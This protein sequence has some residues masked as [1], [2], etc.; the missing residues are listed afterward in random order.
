MKRDRLDA[1]KELA[2]LRIEDILETLGV[3]FTER[4]NYVV[5][6][7]PVHGGSRRDAFS[8]HLERGIWKCF[9]RGCEEEHGADIFGLVRAIRKCTFND[10]IRFIE[11]FVDSSLS[12]EEIQRLK[13]KKA[14]KEFIQATQKKVERLKTYDPSCLSKLTKHG[15]LETRGYPT[16]L[17]ERYHIGAC[18]E[19]HRYMSNRIVVPVTN[20]D[21]EI[22]GFTG[23]TL[24]ASWKDKKIPKWKHSK[25]AWVSMN[26]FNIDNAAPYIE[27][28]GAVILVEGPLDV[29]RFEQAGVHNSVAIL[30]KKFYSEQMTIIAGCGATRIV[31]A[32]DNDAAGQSGSRGILKTAALLFQIE[33]A[34]IPEDRK[35]VGEMSL[36]EIREVFSEFYKETIR[37]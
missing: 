9:S 18:L 17:V 16:W 4:Y 23:R 6:P 13:D 12:P 27:E 20:I 1:I 7:C 26:L 11:R 25:G 5:A 14:N 10:A 24:D 8:W 3:D 35:D 28:C 31:D 21:G 2:H 30:G 36:E 15:Y 32:L 34:K 19:P 22:V 37:N 29:L 33:K